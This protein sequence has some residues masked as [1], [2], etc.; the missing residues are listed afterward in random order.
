MADASYQP[1]VYR[2]QGGDEQVVASGGTLTVESGGTLTNA[3]T[4]A[5]TGALTNTGTITN[6]SD[7]YVA[8]TVTA[9][10]T[11]QTLEPYGA[12]L[13]GSTDSGALAYKLKKPSV[14]GQH[15]YITIRKSTAGG[16]TIAPATGT[17]ACKFN[18]SK[19]KITAK[20]ALQGETLHLFAA[21][22]TTWCIVGYSTAAATYT[23][24]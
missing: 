16:L 6:S 8:E 24:T 4:F 14:A 10:S 5:N 12:S 21:S 17:N 11:A 22:S 18:Y 9:K 19:V 15:K 23:C 3:G 20:T 13:I 7:A 2:K 1:K